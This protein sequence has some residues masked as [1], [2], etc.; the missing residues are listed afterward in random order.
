MLC[1]FDIR[2]IMIGR[3]DVLDDC[4]VPHILQSILFHSPLSD[5]EVIKSR[6]LSEVEVSGQLGIKV[7]DL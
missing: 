1:A 5:P 4:F 3:S 6:E 2:Y 7:E